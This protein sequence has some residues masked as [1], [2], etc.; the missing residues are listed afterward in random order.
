LEI[1]FGTNRNA[2]I[3]KNTLQVDRELRPKLIRKEFSVQDSKLKMYVL[4]KTLVI[5]Y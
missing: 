1:D 2:T 4:I 3:A 5:L